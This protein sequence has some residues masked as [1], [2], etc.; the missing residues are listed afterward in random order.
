MPESGKGKVKVSTKDNCNQD[1]E[2]EPNASAQLFM[3]SYRAKNKRIL[4]PY[5]RS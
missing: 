1:R 5:P 3:T 4:S 2:V